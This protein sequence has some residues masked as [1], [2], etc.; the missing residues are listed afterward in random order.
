MTLE[1]NVGDLLRNNKLTRVLNLDRWDEARYLIILYTCTVNKAYRLQGKRI[2]KDFGFLRAVLRDFARSFGLRFE[3]YRGAGRVLEDRLEKDFGYVKSFRDVSSYTYYALTGEG[4]RVAESALAEA[5]KGLSEG[6]TELLP[7]SLLRMVMKQIRRIEEE[8]GVS[9]H[10]RE[11]REEY[12]KF[13]AMKL[14]TEKIR[15]DKTKTVKLTKVRTRIG[16]SL[17]N[18]L[19]FPDDRYMSRRHAEIGWDGSAYRIRDLNSKNGTWRTDSR[20]K[21]VRVS[22]EVLTSDVYEVGATRL[23][24]QT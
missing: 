10:T 14:E 20:G 11:L 18:A 13:E 2:G 19:S 16:R 7:T 24:F 9:N 3:F 17:D 22:N 1:D 8:E 23:R 15:F 12:E 6:E 4:R 5:A 21:R